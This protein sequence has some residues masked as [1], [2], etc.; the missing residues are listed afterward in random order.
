MPAGPGA[1]HLLGVLVQRRQRLGGR[2][3]RGDLDT[4]CRG[5]RRSA[6]PPPREPCLARS[7]SRPSSMISSRPAPTVSGAVARANRSELVEGHLDR[8]P[9]VQE[10]AVGVQP[11][12]A[13]PRRL[14]RRMPSRQAASARSTA[15]KATTWPSASR[16]GVTSRT[17]ASADE[18]LVGRVVLGD[19]V[20]QVRV[21]RRRQPG[22]VEVL[23]PP[24]VEPLTGQRV[25]A[26]DDAVLL[27]PG[28]RTGRNVTWRTVSPVPLKTVTVTRRRPLTSGTSAS[29][30]L[31]R[32]GDLV[33]VRGSLGPGD[34][35][36]RRRGSAGSATSRASPATDCG[37][38]GS[39]SKSVDGRDEVEALAAQVEVAGDELAA[40]AH[41]LRDVLQRA[42][43]VVAAGEHLEQRLRPRLSATT[44]APSSCTTGSVRS[45]MASMCS[46]RSGPSGFASSCWRCSWRP[47]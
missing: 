43:L 15:G 12:A 7:C 33:G 29:R 47:W 37:G 17:S 34:D 22:A 30:S 20:E 44:R 14:C 24:Q 8:R 35:R 23:Q 46:A 4:G 9:D 26:A 16:S 32:R 18:P 5:G 41:E 27:Q 19:E 6:A 31:E 21:L 40:V 10:D 28:P 45:T 25:H 1:P 2:R 39:P 36:G 42:H 13:A 3:A 38:R 11:V